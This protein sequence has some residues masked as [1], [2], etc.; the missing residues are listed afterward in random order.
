MSFT[1]VSSGDLIKASVSNANWRHFGRADL[2]SFYP[3]SV[4]G[5]YTAQDLGEVGKEWGSIYG[6]LNT[7]FGDGSDGAFSSADA[8]LGGVKQ[9][10]DFTLNA[11]KT[12]TITGGGLVLLVNGT[13]TL[14][15][16][17][18]G[19]GRPGGSN[20]GGA[21]GTGGGISG[22]SD[23]STYNAAGMGQ[24]GCGSNGVSTGLTGGLAYGWGA[25]GGDGGA[26]YSTGRSAT[27][28]D[29]DALF[30]R[31]FMLSYLKA[32]L[33]AIGSGGSGG[34][35]GN[36]AGG[37][38]AGSGGGGGGST[39]IIICKNIVRGTGV[40]TCAG[41]SSAS[42]PYDS[43]SGGGGGGGNIVLMYK[44][45]VSGSLPTL[46]V[47]GGVAGLVNTIGGSSATRGSNGSAGYSNTVAL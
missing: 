42:T 30:Q 37:T 22:G 43:G 26:G 41:G 40:V 1:A 25:V 33:W 38:Q 9:Y 3:M 24:G 10:T 47:S 11:G 12:I 4:S 23:V 34:S 16:T 45:L 32:G 35:G 13:L 17:I 7:I 2:S 28:S 20:S 39:L 8:S 6:T 36:N 29:V 31:P 15:G 5:N 19:D 46:N 21:G 18:S 44:Y 14:N 27:P